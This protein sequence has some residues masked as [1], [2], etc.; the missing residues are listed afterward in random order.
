MRLG[1]RLPTMSGSISCSMSSSCAPSLTGPRT[2]S[3]P[4]RGRA[5]CLP[6]RWLPFRTL[7]RY[8]AMTYLK[9]FLLAAAALASVFYITTFIDLSEKVFKGAAT[10]AMLGTFFWYTTP[11][12]VYYILPLSALVATLVT[13]A[14]LTKSSELVAMKAC[15]IASSRAQRPAIPIAEVRL[16]G[17]V[18]R[19]EVLHLDPGPRI[20]RNYHRPFPVLLGFSIERDPLDHITPR[21][22]LQRQEEMILQIL[23]RRCREH[24]RVLD[25]HGCSIHHVV[26]PRDFARLRDRRHRCLRDGD[27]AIGATAHGKHRQGGE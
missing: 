13:V 20:E 17:F 24:L 2:S 19:A 21:T 10:W 12:Y 9:I 16:R 11:Q 14:L 4:G 7:D 22:E 15:G 27:P 3:R 25:R 6:G 1:C 26:S 8:V 23:I 5:C 18:P